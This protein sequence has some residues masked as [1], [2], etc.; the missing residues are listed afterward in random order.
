MV[1]KCLGDLD[2]QEKTYAE[3]G[4]IQLEPSTLRQIFDMQGGT[5]MLTIVNMQ[6]MLYLCIFLLFQ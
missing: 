2:Y 4:I 6:W 1:H 3:L 5:A